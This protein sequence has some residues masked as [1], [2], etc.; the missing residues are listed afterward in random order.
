M[1]VKDIQCK[2]KK[3]L[4]VGMSGAYHTHISTSGAYRKYFNQ[5][6]VTPTKYIGAAKC[7]YGADL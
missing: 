3:K 1:N 4:R 5:R 7:N 6:K 2:H